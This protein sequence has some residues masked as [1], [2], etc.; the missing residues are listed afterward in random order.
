MN[1]GESIVL[2]LAERYAAAFGL[3]FMHRAGYAIINKEN[4]LFDARLFDFSDGSFEN[5]VFSYRDVSLEFRTM[6]EGDSSG[7]FAPPVFLE[8]SRAKH[9]VKTEVNGSN[10]TVV[11][12]WGT[13]PYKVAVSG[14]IVDMEEHRYPAQKIEQ[15]HRLFEHNGIIN[16]VGEQFYDKDIESIYLD[17]V[18]IKPLEGFADTVQIRLSATAIRELHF[19][20]INPGI[21]V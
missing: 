12:R 8:F 15:L 4:G 13:K 5:V 6:L 9:F 20:L 18:S 10:Y 7:I 17:D 11:E 19:D 14:L 21:D 16:V 3:A 2:N 1:N